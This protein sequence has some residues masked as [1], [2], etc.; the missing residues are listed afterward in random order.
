LTD[1]THTK[2]NN[3]PPKNEYVVQKGTKVTLVVFLVKNDQNTKNY[4]KAYKSRY[5]ILSP[6][7]VESQNR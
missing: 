3:F 6:N 4:Y 7:I 5:A 1:F 2:S